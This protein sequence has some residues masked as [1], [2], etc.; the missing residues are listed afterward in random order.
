MAWIVPV[1]LA[2][3]DLGA[4]LWGANKAKKE[5]EEANR[6]NRQNAAMMNLISVLYCIGL[7]ET[8]PVIELQSLSGHALFVFSIHSFDSQ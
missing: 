8:R 4:N 1:S 5:A 3:L 2:A 7:I 6:K